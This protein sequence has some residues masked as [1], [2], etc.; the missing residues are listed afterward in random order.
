M[1][2]EIKKDVQQKLRQLV[3]HLQIRSGQ[4]SRLTNATLPLGLASSSLA[5]I[6]QREETAALPTAKSL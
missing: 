6:L 4:Q 2:P 1:R 3:Q 5:C